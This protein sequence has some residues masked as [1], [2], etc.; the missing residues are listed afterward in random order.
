MPNYSTMSTPVPTPQYK[1][2]F[3]HIPLTNSKVKV[4]TKYVTVPPSQLVPESNTLRS[5][6]FFSFP[7]DEGQVNPR[8]S[9]LARN[10]LLIII[11]FMKVILKAQFYLELLVLSLNLVY[12]ILVEQYLM[13]M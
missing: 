12:K 10:T 9:L 6:G 5:S 3:S 11:L 4:V 8:R 1:K 7:P 2:Y 13:L